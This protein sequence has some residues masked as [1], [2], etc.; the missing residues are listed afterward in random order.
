LQP[1]GL[2]FDRRAYEGD[3]FGFAAWPGAL[4]GAAGL[5]LLMQAQ[6]RKLAIADLGL[7]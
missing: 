6:F 1:W 7:G 4:L 3:V 2:D 5:F